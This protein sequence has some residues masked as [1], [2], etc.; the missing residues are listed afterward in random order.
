MKLSVESTVRAGNKGI[1]GLL[2]G[3]SRCWSVRLNTEVM[4]TVAQ[5]Q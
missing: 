1:S 4:P 5:E 3:A 2:S